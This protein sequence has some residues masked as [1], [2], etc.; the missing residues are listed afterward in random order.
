MSTNGR[1]FSRMSMPAGG[2]RDDSRIFATIRVPGF[3]IISLTA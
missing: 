3:E 2:I 1:E